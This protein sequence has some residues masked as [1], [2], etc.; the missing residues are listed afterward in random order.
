M[1]IGVLGDEK[2]RRPH[3]EVEADEEENCR[4]QRFAQLVKKPP[5]EPGNR[6]GDCHAVVTS[7]TW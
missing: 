2:V 1:T 6:R 4:R 7:N 5:C 3:N